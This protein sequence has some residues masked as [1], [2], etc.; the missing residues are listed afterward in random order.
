VSPLLPTGAA[1]WRFGLVPGELFGA[2]VII[3]D[4]G[5]VRTVRNAFTIPGGPVR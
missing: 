2:D 1:A 4:T 3:V 5:G